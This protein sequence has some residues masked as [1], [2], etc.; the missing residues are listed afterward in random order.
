MGKNY[1]E[2]GQKVQKIGLESRKNNGK[3]MKIDL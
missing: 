1:D 2:N 3:C